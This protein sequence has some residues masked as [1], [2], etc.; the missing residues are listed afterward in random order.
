M[1]DEQTTK[2]NVPQ[3]LLAMRSHGFAV[4][5]VEYR[6]AIDSPPLGGPFPTWLDDAAD[7]VA[8]L[9]SSASKL[10]LDSSRF[11]AAGASAGA[12]QASLLGLGNSSLGLGNQS[13]VQGVIAVG[14]PT[15]LADLGVDSDALPPI[16]PPVNASADD[17]L[18]CDVY[19]PHGVQ[20]WVGL[21]LGCAGLASCTP[22]CLAASPL[23]YAR[24]DAPPSLLVAG[25]DDCVVP[26][27]QSQRLFES[28]EAAGAP[29]VT[30]HLEPGF[31]HMPVLDAPNVSE[32][33]SSWLLKRFAVPSERRRARE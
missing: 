8:W 24:A 28:L 16:C 33:I 27:K 7:A 29:D 23:S 12:M 21:A 14:T 5:S 25:S 18:Y 2:A 6:L 17:R 30:L 26:P 10:G 11:V 20:C 1:S 13:A 15:A 3:L 31:G 22:K 32:L 19:T 9:R 4:A